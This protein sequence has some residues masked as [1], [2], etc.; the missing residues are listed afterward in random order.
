MLRMSEISLGLFLLCLMGFAPTFADLYQWTDHRGV[1]H[2]VDESV[3]I[4]EEFVSSVKVYHTRTPSSAARTPLPPRPFPP[5]TQGHFAQKLAQDLGLV[6]EAHEDPLAA[7]TTVGIAPAGGWRAYDPLSPEAAYE[8]V[9]AARRAAEARR[10]SLSPDG[11]EAVVQQALPAKPQEV[12]TF[13]PPEEAPFYEGPTV[14]Y[15]QEV[16][17]VGPR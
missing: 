4:P 8:V 15:V 10:L 6:Q 1:I 14:E 17:E 13:P 7:L 9:A 11:A 12:P 5:T 3:A 2:I 16:I